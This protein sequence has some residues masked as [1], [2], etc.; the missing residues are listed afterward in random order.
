MRL[1]APLLGAVLLL[2]GCAHTAA[3]DDGLGFAERQARLSEIADWNLSGQLVVD[4]GERR[5]R[6]RVAWEQRGDHLSL[7]VRGVVIG[8]GS[9]RVVGDAAQLVI[10]GRGEP[11]V[12]DD[13][14]AEL[15]R[16]LG[17]PLPVT[18]L[19]S[20]LL[21]QPDAAYPERVDRGPAGVVVVLTQRDW[22]VDYE[23]YQVAGGLL[24]PRAIALTQGQLKLRLAGISWAPVSAA[25]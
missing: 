14:E 2:A 11:R 25:P 9:L 20:W 3:I 5:D 15:S 10:E 13:P 19:E 17:W 4:T 1:C 8:A 18:S 16:E 22:R 21:G 7:T 6:F 24:V 12:L 23:E